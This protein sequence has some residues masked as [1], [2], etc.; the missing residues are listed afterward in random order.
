MLL[1]ETKEVNKWIGARQLIKDISF[2]IYRGDKIGFVGHNG[3][4]KSTFLKIIMGQDKEF[5]GQVKLNARV[6][7]LPQFYEYPT[8]QTVEEFFTEQSYDYGSFLRM[9]KEFGFETNFLDRQIETC[10]GGEQTKLQLI[11]ILIEEPEL[12]ILDEPTNHLDI[13][14]RDWIAEFLN[15]FQGG[16]LL[17]SHDRYFLDQVVE[18]IWELEESKA[19]NNYTGNYS[20]YRKQ[21]EIE[22]ARKWQE[23]EKYQAEQK[24]LKETVQKQQQ[25]VN[26]A[27]KGRKRTDSFW[28]QLKGSDRRTG[29]MAKRV[30][31]L[32][33]QIEQVEHKEKPVKS[34]KINPGFAMRDLHSEIIIQG[35]NISKS[36]KS[37]IVLKDLNFSISR[38]SKIV[39]LGKNG[40]GKSVLIKLIHGKVKPTQGEVI[41]AECVDIGYFSQK[42]ANLHQDYTVIEEVQKK[43]SEISE[44]VIRTF[45]GSMLFRG[46]DV[47]KRVGDLSIG[48]RVRV[49]FT[50]LLLSKANFLLLD[51]PLN[52]LDIVS[53]ERIE[54]ALKSYSGSFLIV[55]H[56]RYFARETAN[57]IWELNSNGLDCFKGSYKDFLKYKQGDFKTGEELDNELVKMKRVELL[58]RLEQARDE[59][60]IERINIELDQ[61]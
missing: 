57:E 52:H 31:A 55:T 28:R 3:T 19:I 41:N 27:D 42:L 44:E 61:L 34:K 5:Q 23:Y 7:Y 54:E 10:S 16:I 17:V 26:K 15:K 39:L 48:E 51:E 12:L 59:E 29:R 53:R 2:N 22:V 56:D 40:V 30:K 6:G 18:E 38:G 58:V 37:C 14:T 50:I 32:K 47:F 13:E 35:K 20:E 60:E 49:A 46:K 4:G 21:K 11:R 36:F 45:L 24:R 8:N 43:N 33:N 9:M 1:V 25:F